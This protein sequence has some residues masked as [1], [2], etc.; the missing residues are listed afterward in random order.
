MTQD[1]RFDRVEALIEQMG[2]RLMNYTLEFRREVSGRLQA[3]ETEMRV[4]ASSQQ[5]FDAK[6]PALTKAAFDSSSAISSLYG[7]QMERSGAAFELAERMRKLEETV[8]KLQK[9]AA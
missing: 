4:L 2:E 8:A 5:S 9:P 6:L 3:V 7:I 1:E